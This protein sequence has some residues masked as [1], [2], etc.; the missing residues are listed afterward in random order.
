MVNTATEVVP[1]DQEV[2]Q[3]V[4]SAM[5]R[6]EEAFYRALERA[7]EQ[8]GLGTRPQDLSA[9]ARFLNNT[10]QGLQVTGK[11][12]REKKTLQQIVRVS[13]SALA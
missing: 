13:L 2:A 10:L 9:L 7:D 1:H 6:A 5:K 11:V 4:C 8:G 12:I 3:T